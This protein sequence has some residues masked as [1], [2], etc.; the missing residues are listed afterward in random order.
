MSYCH[1]FQITVNIFIFFGICHFYA[2]IILKISLL[3]KRGKDITMYID[4]LLTSG[5]TFSKDEYELRFKYI[6]FNILILFNITIADTAA[7]VR[8]VN[9]QYMLGTADIVYMLF[10]SSAFLIARFSK[11]SLDTLMYFVIF[12]SYAIITFLFYHKLNPVAGTAWYI[13]VLMISF[14][15]KGRKT[16]LFVFIFSLLTII[17]ISL[18]HYHH[19]PHELFLG[20]LPYTAV[21]FFLYI[22]DKQNENL[23]KTI[24]TQKKEYL[25]LSR[26]D[27]LTGIPNRAFF[28]HKLEQLLASARKDHSQIALLFIDLNNFKTINDTFG[29]QIG[30]EILKEVALRIQKLLS[31][32]EIFARYGGDEF[33]LIIQGDDLYTFTEK[34]IVK[35]ENCMKPPIRLQG[36]DHYITLSIGA[37]I[38]PDDG[39]DEP[40]LLSNAD[41][42]MYY[43]KKHTQQKHAFYKDIVLSY[44]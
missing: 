16:G 42:A 30:D 23:K 26:H 41:K 34:R 24:N 31:G 28:F 5:H 33:A 12:F 44:N 27:T 15:F 1:I 38:F 25:H 8:M 29:H 32:K 10:A 21:I 7:I 39:R 40:T 3:D 35:I 20:L 9:K 4:N 17:S 6:L 19:T 18:F 43:A 11:K 36:V 14:V 13:L 37:T 2:R 22:F